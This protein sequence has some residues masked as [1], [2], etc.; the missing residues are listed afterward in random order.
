MQ[1]LFFARQRKTAPKK[2]FNVTRV[3]FSQKINGSLLAE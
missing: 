3:S 1:G 2:A